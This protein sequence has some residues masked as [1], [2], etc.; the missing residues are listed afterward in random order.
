[1]V[2]HRGTGMTA[3]ASK[4]APTLDVYLV[5]RGPEFFG[6]FSCVGQRTCWEISFEISTIDVLPVN[7]NFTLPRDEK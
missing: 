5:S 2:V 4:L 7:S 6:A 1:M 3:F